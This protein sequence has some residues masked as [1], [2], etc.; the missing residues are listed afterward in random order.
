MGGQA[1]LAA[2]AASLC[3]AMDKGGTAMPHPGESPFRALFD[4]Q[5]MDICGN[6][7]KLTSEEHAFTKVGAPEGQDQLILEKYNEF[8]ACL[9]DPAL[10]E[11]RP[12]RFK[13]LVSYISLHFVIECKLMKLL[14][15]PDTERHESQHNNFIKTIDFYVREIQNERSTAEELVL[16]IGHWLLGHALISDQA[17]GDFE[18]GL[19]EADDIIHQA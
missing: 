18:A 9:R 16:Y 8:V 12:E 6:L 4:S 19:S 1:A 11:V 13:K 7:R 5:I 3:K 17:F 2:S 14:G 10:V 15:Y